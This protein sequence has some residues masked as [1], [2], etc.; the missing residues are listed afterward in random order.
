MIQDQERFLQSIEDTDVTLLPIS[1]EDSIQ[2]SLT[3]DLSNTHLLLLGEVHGVYEN[4]HIIYFLYKQWGFR[5]LALEWE[6]DLTETIYSYLRTGDLDFSMIQ[7]SNDGR[8][9]SGHFAL[10]K[11]LQKEGVLDSIVCFHPPVWPSTDN[12]RDE[13]MAHNILSSFL[14]ENTLVVAGN[15]HTQRNRIIQ[16]DTILHPMGEYLV[17]E[18]PNIPLCNIKY[19]SGSFYNFEIEDFLT[20]DDN[21]TQNYLYQE[22]EIYYLSLGKAHPAIIPHTQSNCST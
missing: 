9:T 15:Y 14:S 19:R 17:K 3:Q 5:P 20:L 21:I 11:Q 6:Q 12:G 2:E 18:I 13:L 1:V 7:K 10:L 8:I 16:G 4:P 22:D